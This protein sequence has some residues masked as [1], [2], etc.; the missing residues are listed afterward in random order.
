MKLEEAKN[1][2]NVFKAENISQNSKKVHWEIFNWFRN[3]QKL[4]LNYLMII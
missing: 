2:E 4:L 1:L 3:H